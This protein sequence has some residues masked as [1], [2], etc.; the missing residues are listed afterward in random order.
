MD[1]LNYE[2]EIDASK[3]LVRAKGD[4]EFVTECADKFS[5]V[6]TNYSGVSAPSQPMNPPTG[7]SAPQVT[8]NGG[9]VTDSSLDQYPNVFDVTGESI[10]VI[11]DL[12]GNTTAGKAKNLALLYL[13]ARLRLGDEVIANE[14][15]REQCK[16]HAVYDSTN[17][18]SQMRSQKKLVTVQGTKGS[19]NFT[20]KL[21][22]PGRKKAEEIAKELNGE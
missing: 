3:G 22:I 5:N 8:E 11:A 14:D 15:V 18:A 6:Y 12:P 7:K 9:A 19:P 1:D 21:T 10:S 4:K 20:L 16:S 17:F 2:I 13:L